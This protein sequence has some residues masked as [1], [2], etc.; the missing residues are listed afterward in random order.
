MTSRL[1]DFEK[2]PNTRDLG[3]MRTA[4]GRAVAAGKLI[5]SGQLA[6]LPDADIVKLSG[7]I[8]TIAD[9]RTEEEK[10]ADPDCVIPGASYHFI[11]I[12]ESFSAGVSREAESEEQIIARLVFDPEASREH[13]CNMYRKFAESSY[14]VSQY[15]RFMRIL[16]EDHDRAVLWH[17]SVG[18]DRAGTAAVII[19]KIL[20]VPEDDIIRDYLDTNKYLKDDLA[21][22]TAYARMKTGSDDP[23]IALSMSRLYGTDSLYISAFLDAAD[24]RFGSFDGFVRDGLGLSGSDIRLLKQ[25]YLD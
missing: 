8:D 2:L 17:C 19:L 6:G 23:R 22:V 5:R 15:A 24:R 7:L 1:L 25:K 20:G 21:R 18:K 3:G 10:I 12:M 11:P 9:F 16:L 14:S 4:D 13:M